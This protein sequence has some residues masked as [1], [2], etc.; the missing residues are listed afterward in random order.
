MGDNRDCSNDSRID[1]GY[2]NKVNVIGK[3]RFIF[4]SNDTLKGSVL[5]IWNWKNSFR[6]DRF[7]KKL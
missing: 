4:F 6:I 3:A 5:K 2:V 1:V 7:F